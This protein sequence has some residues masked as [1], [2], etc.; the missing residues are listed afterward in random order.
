MW[1]VVLRVVASVVAAVVTGVKQS[2][3]QVSRLKPE[4]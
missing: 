1:W 2:Q 3:L 4:A